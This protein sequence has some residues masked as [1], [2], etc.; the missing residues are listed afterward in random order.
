MEVYISSASDSDLEEILQ[1]QKLAFMREAERCNDFTIAPLCQTLDE[2]R[3]EAKSNIIIKA[4]ADGSI[5]GSA[6]AF[7]KQGT[8]YIGRV[9]VHPDCQN[10]GIGKKLMKAI[11]GYFKG[12]RYELFTGQLSEKNLAFYEALGYKR[13]DIRRVNDKLQLV[14]LEKLPEAP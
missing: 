10:M 8:C 1:L 14:Y 11:E 9:I 3:E 13:F 6:R 2:I 5:V 7:E 12:C 4:V